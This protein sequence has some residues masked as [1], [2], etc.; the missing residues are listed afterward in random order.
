MPKNASEGGD[1]R[2]HHGKRK[3]DR[4]H[5]QDIVSTERQQASALNCHS[6]GHDDRDQVGKEQPRT[7][8]EDEY[9][10]ENQVETLRVGQ[11]RG[12]EISTHNPHRDCKN[13]N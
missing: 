1:S 7:H 2:R 4:K 3:P 10:I 12:N 13:D 11:S 6:K 8:P 9:R 5:T